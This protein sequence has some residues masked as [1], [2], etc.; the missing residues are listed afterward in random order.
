MKPISFENLKR[1]MGGGRKKKDKESSF[2]RSE[3]FKRISIR[4]SYLD[5]GKKRHLHKLEVATQTVVEETAAA[6]VS[7]KVD[8]SVQVELQASSSIESN[9]K[10]EG[11]GQSVIAY[12]QWLKCIKKED[13]TNNGKSTKG[14]ERTIIYVPASDEIKA[15]LIRKLS[16]SPT[17]RKKSLNLDKSS[18]NLQRQESNDSALEMFPWGDST[19]VRKSPIIRRRTKTPPLMPDS[20]NEELCSLSISLGRIWMDAPQVMAPRSLEMPRTSQSAVHAHNSLDSALKDLRDDPIVMNRLQKRTVLPIGRTL[21]STSNT[22]ASTG[23]FSSKDSGFS[24]SIPK[25]SD[26]SLMSRRLF[27]KKRTKPKLS[28]SRDNY[29]KRTSEASSIRRHS[30]RKKKTRNSLRKPTK[31]ETYQITGRPYNRSLKSLKMDPMIFVPPEKRKPTDKKRKCF[32]IHE[33]RNLTPCIDTIYSKKYADSD[34]GLY[35]SLIGD[36]EELQ[37]VDRIS[38]MHLRKKEE[39]HLG[40]SDAFPGNEAQLSDESSNS[41]IDSSAASDDDYYYSS[42]SISDG[43]CPPVGVSSSAAPRRRPV[44][45]RRSELSRKRSITYVAKPTILRVPS[46]LRRPHKKV[47]E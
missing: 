24:F 46:T 14:A 27:R 19:E 10:R 7:E 38:R 9:E 47:G 11:P 3:S 43:G 36:A 13:P 25:L 31:G 42:S 6:S 35:E 41:E 15:P 8:S 5:R 28:V 21:S 22:T 4:K 1:L 45:R 29:F 40:G 2:K 33:I 30:S 18:P 37:V 32:K 23:L 26:D 16:S 44:R 17:S 39:D 20:G 12:G 34:D